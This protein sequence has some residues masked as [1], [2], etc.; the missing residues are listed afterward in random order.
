MS[1]APHQESESFGFDA[2][3]RQL[4]DLVI[5]SL[6]SDKEIF[7]R[8]LI[9]NASDALDRARLMSLSNSELRPAEGE[10]GIRL[11]VDEA[12]GTLTITDN[13][14]GLSAEQAKKALG[15]IAHSGTKA[16][17]QA[18]REKG[19]GDA[20]RLI[21]QFGVGFYSALM[22]ADHVEVHSLGGDPEATPIVWSCDGSTTY[23]LRAGDRS[24]RGTD[25]V[26]K[27]REDCREYLDEGRIRDIVRKHSEFVPYPIRMGE[28]QLNEPQALWTRA[29]SE[30]GE[31]EYKSFYKHLS[32]D[33]AEPALW[34]HVSADAPI[35]YRALMYLPTHPPYD[36]N[37]MDGRRI[38]RLYA[39]RV[40]IDDEARK[41]LPDYLRFV[42]GV[43][44]SED[45][46]LNVSRELV[47]KTP[48][49]EKI[50]KQLTSR[51]LKRL[52]EYAKDNAE[53]YKSF[54]RDF[55]PVL[56]EGLHSDSDNR[57]KLLDL[58]RFNTTRSEDKSGLRSLAEIVESM[59]EGQ[60]AIWY[61]T[62]P[63]WETTSRSPHLEAFRKRGWE[64]IL[65][66][67]PID[68]WAVQSVTNYK[69]KPLKSVARGDLDLEKD[70]Q[71]LD[72][73]LNGWLNGLL[74]GEVKEVR[75]SGRL[76]DSPSVLVDDPHGLSANMERLLRS[77]QKDMPPTQRILEV[78][79]AHPWV[80]ALERLHT[81]GRD[82]E[83]E[84]LARL[85]LDQ[86]QLSEGTVKDP[87]GLVTRLR[88][89]G[90]LAAKGLGV[91]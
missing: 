4:L 2:E 12:A 28:D 37:Y 31:D 3:V 87:V 7:L 82:G 6:Y 16:F 86:A 63:D 9:S 1:D 36:M 52:G 67:D 50:R 41:L 60:D 58:A 24:T 21:G 23:T 10:P 14:I 57:E 38:V 17:A 53:D 85:L 83:A 64:V 43:V 90:D 40:L 69:D 15:T 26:L 25:I 27:L 81:D 51:L 91:G 18:V 80:K 72:E 84:P 11:S 48:V 62:G 88:T 8:E 70:E 56:K 79:P 65:L 5:H 68:E 78:N 77:M 39:K 20:S 71:K 73:G 35:Q 47:Q 19:Q 55:G 46:Q 54:W 13:G 75:S 74:G 76:T 42:R 22:V 49:V 45:L 44:D 32:G 89:L 30:I 61:L 34:M 29:A 33:W 66:T 59:P